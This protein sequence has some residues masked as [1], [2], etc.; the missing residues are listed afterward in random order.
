MRR[1][2]AIRTEWLDL[3][4]Q[5]LQILNIYIKIAIAYFVRA[6]L[7]LVCTMETAWP[8]DE[9]KGQ[10][11]NRQSTYE[12]GPWEMALTQH[13]E[14]YLHC[15]RNC[16]GWEIPQTKLTREQRGPFS[17]CRHNWTV[18]PA[19]GGHNLSELSRRVSVNR[20]PSHG[21]NFT[22]EQAH[23]SKSSHIV[24]NTRSIQSMELQF[25]RAMSPVSQE[26]VKSLLSSFL[27]FLPLY[28]SSP[29]FSFFSY[30]IFFFFFFF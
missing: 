23:R 22:R 5:G 26:I 4:G 25:H 28:S 30:C 19:W 11:V 3:V 13:E 1:T 27:L 7:P 10:E 24:P 18:S 15:L 16:A 29:P 2:E 21:W 20:A 6:A 14:P 12:P 8:G 9:D 17:L